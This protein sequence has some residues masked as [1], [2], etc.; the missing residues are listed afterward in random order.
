MDKMN[1][2]VQLVEEGK[3]SEGLSLLEQMEGQADDATTFT[4]AQQYYEWGHVEKAKALVED[5]LEW[6]PEEGE[7][8][9]FLAEILIDSDE[10]EQA[11]ERLSKVTSEDPDYPRALLLLADV[12]GAQ[13]LD[14]VAEQKLLEAKRFMP[15]EPVISFALGEFYVSLGDFKKSVPYYRE[16]LS[17]GSSIDGENIHLR[18]AESLGGSGQFEEALQH[19]EKGLENKVEL[20]SLSG[21]GLTAYRIGEYAKSIQAFEEL[22][23]LDPDYG[24]LY[25][26]LARSYEAEGALPEGYETISEGTTVDPLNEEIAYCRGELALKIGELEEADRYL[27]KAL[28]INPAHLPALKKLATFLNKQ[29]RDDEVIELLSAVEDEREPLFSW[30]LASAYRNEEQYDEALKYYQETHT[31][32]GN[33]PEFLEEY[34]DFLLEEG[35]REKALDMY[36]R[37]LEIDVSLFHLKER[38]AHFE[39]EL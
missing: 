21:Y 5:L 34:G 4:I 12:Y 35:R 23:E 30:F 17:G 31:M 14:E 1:K 36:R 26:Y 28:E 19:Y 2:A 6:H 3:V 8:H 27:R 24:S 7:L 22:K 10:E 13:G 38:I 16:A 32:F 18:L 39:D 11:I 15:E 29:G 25:L 33:D 9:L 20:H 37:A